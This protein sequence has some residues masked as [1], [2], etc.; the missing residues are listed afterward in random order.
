M[1]D[2]LCEAFRS[3]VWIYIDGGLSPSERAGWD[4]HMQHCAHCRKTHLDALT[5]EDVY[6]NLPEY[7]TPEPIVQAVARHAGEM[8]PRAARGWIEHPAV[9]RLGPSLVGAALVLG[10]VLFLQRYRRTG[11]GLA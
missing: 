3:Q 5:V 2:G 10:G 7:D 8:L 4:D 6:R 1:R 9:K 11:K